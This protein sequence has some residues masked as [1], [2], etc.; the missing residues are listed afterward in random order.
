VKTIGDKK[1]NCKMYE[2]GKTKRRMKK[3]SEYRRRRKRRREKKR[4]TYKVENS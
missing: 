4:A 1:E 2:I 3:Q